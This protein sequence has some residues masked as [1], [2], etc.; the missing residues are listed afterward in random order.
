[1]FFKASGTRFRGPA[2]ARF[3]G[4][5]LG[6]RKSGFFASSAQR[7]GLKWQTAGEL[8]ERG[9]QQFGNFAGEAIPAREAYELRPLIPFVAQSW[10]G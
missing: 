4:Q 5:N 8:L 10:I 6:P 1:V 9:R 7:H 2:K 3:A